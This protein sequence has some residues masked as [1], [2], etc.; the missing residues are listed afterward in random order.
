M[1]ISELVA[2]LERLREAV[3]DVE[4]TCTGSL[5]KD[6]RFIAD[7]VA[8]EPFESSVETVLERDNEPFGRHVRIYW[9]K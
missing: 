2:E 3:G 6:G 9:Q 4:V 8:G 5:Q 1:K 7:R